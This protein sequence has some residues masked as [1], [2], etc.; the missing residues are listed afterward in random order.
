MIADR[1]EILQ[2]YTGTTLS[3]RPSATRVDLQD[4]RSEQ[5]GYLPSRRR[6]AELLPYMC[7]TVG[8]GV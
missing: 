7:G 3:S 6:K 1:S 4:M 2:V 8:S 5:L